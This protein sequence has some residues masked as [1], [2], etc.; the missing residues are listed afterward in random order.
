M[1]QSDG[2]DGLYVARPYTD[3]L[4]GC[5]I[6]TEP[7]LDAMLG[8]LQGGA[9]SVSTDEESRFSKRRKRNF[10]DFDDFPNGQWTMPIPYQFHP[11]A[12]S[13]LYI[14]YSTIS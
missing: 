12:H 5:V 14:A 6:P 10:G 4:D 2:L 11:G 9:R 1:F 13:K 7:Q 8:R 3:T